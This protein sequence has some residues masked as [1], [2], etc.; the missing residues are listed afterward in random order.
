MLASVLSPRRR[1]EVWGD[2]ENNARRCG[3]LGG[4]LGGL[5][6]GRPFAAGCCVWGLRGGVPAGNVSPARR[7]EG[8]AG[9]VRPGALAVETEFCHHATLDQSEVEVRGEGK[10]GRQFSVELRR[11]GTSCS[12]H[13]SVGGRASLCMTPLVACGRARVSS[14]LL[15]LARPPEKHWSPNGSHNS[16][17]TGANDDGDTAKGGICGC[18]SAPM[19]R[20]VREP[21]LSLP[22]FARLAPAS[23]SLPCSPGVSS[24]DAWADGCRSGGSVWLLFNKFEGGMGVAACESADPGVDSRLLEVE[25][26]ADSESRAGRLRAWQTGLHTWDSRNFMIPA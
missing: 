5:L 16:D 9:S 17:A 23:G 21:T 25:V 13:L 2:L 19:R 11:E 10:E 4:L 22:R 6:G 7:C 18:L 26:P 12:R 1:G 24:L 14:E 15:L 3:T 20:G 8:L